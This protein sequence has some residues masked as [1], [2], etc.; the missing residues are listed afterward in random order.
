VHTYGTDG[1]GLILRG[2]ID[3][4]FFYAFNDQKFKKQKCWKVKFT[5]HKKVTIKEL[6]S[7]SE[8]TF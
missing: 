1:L 6:T 7:F 2:K 3:F 4:V 8:I 5:C